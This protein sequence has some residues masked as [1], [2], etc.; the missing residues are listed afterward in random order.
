MHEPGRKI[1]S[2]GYTLAAKRHTNRPGAH[3]TI[4][5]YLL[6]FEE[7]KEIAYAFGWQDVDGI[8]DNLVGRRPLYNSA[9]K[10]YAWM[11]EQR[12]PNYDYDVLRFVRASLARP[13]KT[14]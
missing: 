3:R 6:T 8:R 5:M 2:Y 13:T 14:E 4:F 1:L 12:V 7:R 11:D 10:M 9:G